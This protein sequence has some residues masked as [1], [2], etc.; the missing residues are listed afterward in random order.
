M[1]SKRTLLKALCGAAL[2]PAAASARGLAVAARHGP[3]AGY[4]PNVMFETHD[5][6]KV[7]FYDDVVKGRLVVFNMMYTACAGIC[8]PNTANLM[9]VQAA[10]GHRVGHDIHLVSLT[11]QPELDTPAALQ[12]YARQ[13]GIRPGWTFLTGRRADMDLVRR[14]LGFYDSDPAEDALLSR[15]TGMLSIGNE[16]LDRWCMMPALTAPQQI[17]HAVRNMA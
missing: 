3:R 16:P 10:L 8:P 1:S 2:L 6:R 12:A 17:A 4:F 14:R 5:G 15:H 7:R 13:Y 9:A 11:L